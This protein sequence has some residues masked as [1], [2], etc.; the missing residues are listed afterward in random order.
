MAKVI[1]P[2]H[3]LTSTNGVRE[4]EVE[5]K[6]FRTLVQQLEAKWPGIEDVLTKTVVAI[7][8]QIHQDAWLEPIGPTAEIFFLH[9]IEG[10]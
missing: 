9:P 4:V 2:D 8:G 10:G 3:M 1:F 6:N 7:D 5:C